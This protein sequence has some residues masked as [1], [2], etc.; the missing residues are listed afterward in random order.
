MIYQSTSI[1]EVIAR[2]IRNTRLQDS[3]YI[4]DMGE[5][6]PEAMGILKTKWV[7]VPRYQD[8][9]I[10]F[11]KGAL[12]C[13]LDY[14]TA[15]EWQGQRVQRM[16][17]AR[18]AEVVRGQITSDSGPED[19]SVFASDPDT[20]ESP[21][22][23]LM[24]T[25]DAVPF[26]SL[27]DTDC[28]QLPCATDLWYDVELGHI[29][30]SFKDGMVRVHYRG[31]P[32][33]EEG[34]PLIPDNEEYKQALYWYCRA[35]MIGAGYKDTVFSYAHCE[36]QFDKYVAKAKGRIKYPSPDQMQS[37]INTLNRLVFDDSYFSRFFHSPNA[38]PQFPI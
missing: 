33:D 36:A 3:S 5:W 14:I 20:V 26:C 30:M 16:N 35:Q 9:N 28:N 24:F 21:N 37:R 31:L 34:F 6:I 29:T 8:V 7:L 15:V 38:E 25:S 2:V 32:L 10:Y 22:G 19:I 23:N 27:T 12:P 13:D 18:M 17:G 4:T 1:K 11:H